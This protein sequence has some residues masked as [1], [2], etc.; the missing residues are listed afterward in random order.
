MV[1][2]MPGDSIQTNDSLQ[3]TFAS[4]A[5]WAKGYILCHTV[6][7]HNFQGKIWFVLGWFGFLIFVFIFCCKGRGVNMEKQGFEWN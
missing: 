7:H 5:V 2:Q 4:K 1:Q 6:K 3:Q